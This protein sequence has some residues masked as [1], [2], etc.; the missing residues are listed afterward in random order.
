MNQFVATQIP[1]LQNRHEELLSAKR[2]FEDLNRESG[3]AEQDFLKFA[4]QC[5]TVF[6]HRQLNRL[7]LSDQKDE[8]GNTKIEESTD[9][10]FADSESLKSEA[11]A[12]DRLLQ[13][14][15]LQIENSLDI[16]KIDSNGWNPDRT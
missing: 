13:L 1:H 3:K 4:Q 5:Q 6:A 11:E 8:F 7:K 12:K 16:A 14:N 10:S 15:L 9:V 2:T